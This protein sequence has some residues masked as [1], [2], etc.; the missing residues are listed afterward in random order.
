MKKAVWKR[1]YP[2]IEGA[3]I[4]KAFRGYYFS[5][6]AKMLSGVFLCAVLA[7]VAANVR[8]TVTL[9]NAIYIGLLMVLSI[10]CGLYYKNHKT[11]CQFSAE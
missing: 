10:I 3:D 8:E 6:I 4:D 2:A 1:D 5:R 7:Y 9:R 11:D